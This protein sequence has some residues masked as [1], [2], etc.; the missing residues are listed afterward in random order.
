MS[1][2]RR[3]FLSGRVFFVTC[4]LHH[5]RPFM[6]N[7]DFQA[8]A[9]AVAGVRKRRNFLLTAYAFMPDHWHAL[10]FPAENDTLPRLMNALKVASAQA[11]N[12][13]HKTAGPLWQCRYYDRAV[14][15]VKEY[16]D[17]IRYMHFNPVTKGLVQ[18]P[19]EWPWSSFRSF[20]GRGPVRL[21]VD[22]LDLPAEETTPL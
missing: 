4:N 3:L 22:R 18:K 13:L 20:G 12:R 11:Y 1:R 17:A 19:G 21:A 16:R 6:K 15:T 7:A 5:R 14:R 8:L 9:D 2:L 10:I